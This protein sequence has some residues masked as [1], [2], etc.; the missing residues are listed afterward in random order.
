M[1]EP[2]FLPHVA[3]PA[4][5]VDVV[6]LTLMQGALH[7]LVVERGRDPFKGALALPGGFLRVDKGGKGG[8]PLDE[9]AARELVEETGLSRAQVL[10]AQVGAFGR[11]GR[12][13]R[14]RVITVAYF[15]LVRPEVAPFVRA[16]SD[17]SAARWVPARAARLAFDH[18]VI[19]AATLE[20]MK[21]DVDRGTALHLAPATFTIPELRAVHE[22]LHG[23]ALDPGNFRRRF[24]KLVER[25]VIEAAPGKRV[26]SRK[27]ARVWRARP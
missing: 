1:N 14:G 2:A 4:V 7:V 22:A 6:V 11:P 13:P 9:A 25:G 8:E 23:A 10:L 17:A 12:D 26:T 21:R 5:T 20:R 27:P 15:A 19:L 3:R 16:G 18:D 24:L